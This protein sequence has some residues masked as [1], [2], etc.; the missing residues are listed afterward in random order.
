MVT[1]QAA[2]IPAESRPANPLRWVPI[3]GLWALPLSTTARKALH[4][5]G[6]QK[7]E[8]MQE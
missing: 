8:S 3:A 5:A 6:I 7:P 1:V 2:R 4:L